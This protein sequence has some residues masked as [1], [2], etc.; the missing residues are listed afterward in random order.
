LANIFITG[1]VTRVAGSSPQGGQA[2]SSGREMHAVTC[3]ST[4]MDWGVQKT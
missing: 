3:R 2:T 4:A 1:I